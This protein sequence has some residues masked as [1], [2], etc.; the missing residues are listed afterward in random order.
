MIAA[1][2]AYHPGVSMLNAVYTAVQARRLPEA[3]G[4]LDNCGGRDN[5]AAWWQ[6]QGFIHAVQGHSALAEQAF[7]HGLTLVTLSG[8]DLRTAGRLHIELG[9]LHGKAGRREDALKAYLLARALMRRTRDSLGLQS[10]AYGLAWSLLESNRVQEAATILDEAVIASG[11]AG[12]HSYRSLV[13]CGRSL[14]ARLQGDQRLALSRAQLARSTAANATLE[15][16]ARYLEG[17]AHWRLGQLQEAEQSFA[18]AADLT[19]EDPVRPLIDLTRCLLGQRTPEGAALLDPPLLARLRFHQAAWALRRGDLAA[20]TGLLE[21]ALSGLSAYELR[22][23]GGLLPDLVGWARDRGYPLPELPAA[24]SRVVAVR[25]R[26]PLELRVNGLKVEARVPREVVALVAYL[27]GHPEGRSG[28]LVASEGLGEQS[29][30]LQSAVDQLNA[31]I[32]D[33][34]A[35]TVGLTAVNGSLEDPDGVRLCLSSTWTWVVDGSGRGTVL[36]GLDSPLAT[37]LTNAD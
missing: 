16:R 14:V 1:D 19:P 31:L 26:N 7:T 2:L 28:Q 17:Q 24:P 23:E 34:G 37:D 36:G 27:H 5:S 13:Q 32:G 21:E 30:R 33:P 4:L 18:A 3:Q 25:V 15:A 11:L 12:G 35:L 6:M 20:T 10:L 22:S 29:A 9:V 8:K